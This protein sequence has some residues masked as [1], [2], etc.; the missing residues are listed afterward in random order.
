MDLFAQVICFCRY[1]IKVFIS[2]NC[3]LWYD[4]LLRRSSRRAASSVLRSPISVYEPH[5]IAVLVHLKL[6]FVFM[7]VYMDSQYL[8]V[9]ILAEHAHVH[10]LFRPGLQINQ[11]GFI[12]LPCACTNQTRN[13]RNVL[14]RFGTWCFEAQAV[15]FWSLQKQHWV[16]GHT[17]ASQRDTKGKNDFTCIG[18]LPYYNT[19]KLHPY[20]EKGQTRRK[21][22][23]RGDIMRVSTK[24]ASSVSIIFAGFPDSCDSNFLTVTLHRSQWQPSKFLSMV[25]WSQLSFW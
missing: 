13:I 24:F 11:G 15:L 16:L 17:S 5:I 9:M 1:S 7:L 18:R 12:L 19:K 4:W 10:F 22:R 21:K 8:P 23:R 14:K 6:H 3:T 2:S 20:R 25:E